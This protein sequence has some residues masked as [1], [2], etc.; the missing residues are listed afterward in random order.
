M[1]PANVTST[2]RPPTKYNATLSGASFSAARPI[3]VTPPMTTSQVR[4]ATV[5][6]TIQVGT[7]NTAFT[8]TAIEL[9]CVNGVV[10][11]AATPATIA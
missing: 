10:V 11:S 2:T 3:D 9:G 4:R 5:T 7:P 6:P 1:R 8:A